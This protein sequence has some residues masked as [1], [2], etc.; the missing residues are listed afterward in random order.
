MFLKS[1]VHFFLSLPEIS[2]Y[3]KYQY[4]ITS[5]VSVKGYNFVQN[6]RPELELKILVL[7]QGVKG[8]Q[9]NTFAV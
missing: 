6:F 1:A 7:I 3:F 8:R 4:I 5:K 2:F 9:Q